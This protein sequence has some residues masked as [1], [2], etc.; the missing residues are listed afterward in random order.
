LLDKAI[1]QAAL[2]GQAEIKVL[3]GA[4]LEGANKFYPACGFTLTDAI[5]QHG[6]TMN[7]YVRKTN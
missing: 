7:V 4:I 6:E 1:Q 3:A 5:I 2:D